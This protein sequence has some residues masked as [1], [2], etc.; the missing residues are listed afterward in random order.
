M[1]EPIDT[2]YDIA[3]KLHAQLFGLEARARSA[4]TTLP[5]LAARLDDLRQV[6][7]GL[8]E[9]LKP[10]TEETE[11]SGEWDGGNEL[12]SERLNLGSLP[13]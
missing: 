8:V 1:I 12:H 11:R 5:D 13:G 3:L 6:A 4:D 10:K 9:R 2:T 7:E